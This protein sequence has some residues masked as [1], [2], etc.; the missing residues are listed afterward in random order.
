MDVAP[1]PCTLS[2]AKKTGNR[3]FGAAERGR[4]WTPVKPGSR[5]GGEVVGS[6]QLP[7]GRFATIDNGL[8]FSLVPW[9]NALERRIG[10]Q[11]AGVG[12]GR[13]L[14]VPSEEGVGVVNWL[15]RVPDCCRVFS[16]KGGEPTFA[17]HAT[18][19]DHSV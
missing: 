19:V 10:Q 11:I 16:T 4:D 1:C 12:W 8:G 3:H 18:Q 9:N 14:V 6:T 15:S 17:A 5:F 2:M 13:G 7:S